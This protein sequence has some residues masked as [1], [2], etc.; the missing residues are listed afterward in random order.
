MNETHILPLGI[1]TSFNLIVQYFPSL[2][3][4]MIQSYF[5]KNFKSNSKGRLYIIVTTEKS[6]QIVCKIATDC[7]IKKKTYHEK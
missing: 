5:L 6:S 7:C 3:P 1:V 4:G 2:F